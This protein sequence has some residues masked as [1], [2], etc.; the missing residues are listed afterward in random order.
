MDRLE[1]GTYIIAGAIPDGDLKLTV[2]NIALL[3]S[4]IEKLYEEWQPQLVV[5]GL[6]LNMDGT[7]Q[8]LH[9]A[10]KNSPIAYMVDSK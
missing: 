4:F 9:S 2:G 1:L 10:P 5:V 7:E 3:S 6:P 8:K